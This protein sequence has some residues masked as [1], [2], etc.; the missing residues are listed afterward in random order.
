[1]QDGK[2][3]YSKYSMAELRQALA[4]VDQWRFPENA[5]R[6]R[7]E[8]EHFDLRAKESPMQ[9]N[10]PGLV[11]NQQVILD[12]HGVKSLSLRL[13]ALFIGVT[14]LN[15]VAGSTILLGVSL[16]RYLGSPYGPIS[17]V[18]CLAIGAIPLILAIMI[19]RHADKIAETKLA[20]DANTTAKP[21][22]WLPPLLVAVGLLIFVPS[23]AEAF[24]QIGFL[25]EY[26][27]AKGMYLQGV[28]ER[29]PTMRLDDK[30]FTAAV[31][32]KIV[33]GSILTF[34]PRV[35]SKLIL[36]RSSG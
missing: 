31:I 14:F 15:V 8:I 9:N 13:F 30:M 33:V 19:W 21:N 1:M 34:K 36:A 25:I 11:P 5:K 4:S 20:D 3:D 29:A 6:I 17:I 18:I 22:D 23:L 7:D 26:F 10:D 2:I 12:A 27:Q 32:L 24:S 28:I 16:Y 35:V